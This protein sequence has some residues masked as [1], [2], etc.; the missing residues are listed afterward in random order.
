[1]HI[2]VI[3]GTGHVGT[4]MIP[5]LIEAGFKVTVV[6]RNKREPYTPH[7][8]WKSVQ[9]AVHDR[10]PEEKAGIF[11]PNILTLNPDIVIDMICFELE[12]A[13]HLVEALR[14]KIQQF[15]HCS[16]VWVHGKTTTVPV[17]EG[18]PRRPIGAYG[19]KKA[20]IETYLLSEARLDH[21]PAVCILPGQIVGEG[22][23]PLNP[24]ANFNPDVYRKLAC[25]EKVI[26]PDEGQALLHHVHGDDVAQLFLQA[27]LHWNTAYGESFHAV[28]PSALT[29]RGYAESVAGWFGQT[30][31]LEFLPFNE[32]Q[33]TVDTEDANSTKAHL[34]HNPNCYSIT[35][36]QRLLNYQP[37]YTSLQAIQGSIN[38]LINAGKIIIV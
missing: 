28:S 27:I 34:D 3:G 7:G 23:I 33:K 25:G 32:W 22:W 18:Q 36:A 24:Q 11:G 38:W 13:R 5:R 16:T 6:T 2:V 31:N 4:Y 21:I 14:G 1:M 26:I 37:R 20:A 12:S 17:D 19:E 35:K 29:L 15:I 9:F 10:Y 8:A 30:T